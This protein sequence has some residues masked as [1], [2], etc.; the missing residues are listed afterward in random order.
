MTNAP[1]IDPELAAGLKASQALP[2][3]AVGDIEGRRAR[4]ELG[5]PTEWASQ[6]VPANV[7]I[8]DFSVP[9]PDGT[10]L[11]ARWYTRDSSEPG[12]AVLYCHGGGMIRGSVALFDRI[13]ARYVAGSG[14][15]FL[16]VEYR[17]APEYPYPTPVE[18]VYAGLVWLHEHASELGVTPERICVMGDSAGGGLAAGLTLLARD[19]G[20]P[21]IAHQILLYPMLDDR[22]TVPDPRFDGIVRWGY[23][24]N[25]TGWTAF[26]GDAIGTTDVP[27]YAAP[28]R[29]QDL[30]GL[31][32]TYIEL[33]GLDIFF[34]EDIA[35]AQRLSQAGVP[36]ELHVHPGAPHGFEPLA[37]D[38]SVSLRS[39]ADRVR[40]L[41]SI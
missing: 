30:S 8:R 5:M 28:A 36:I 12:S 21:P 31:P 24:D 15:P 23:G 17:L 39:L 35:Y 29:A 1:W 41:Q 33:G 4:T 10:Q 18:D 25:L 40:V 7:S 38:S 6:P 37:F 34:D 19:R 11:L 16:S 3:L 22:N 32:P 9:A 14:V 13:V 26:L 27:I 2:P 20:G